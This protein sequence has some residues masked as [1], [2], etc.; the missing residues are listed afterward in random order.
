P[1]TRWFWRMRRRIVQWTMLVFSSTRSCWSAVSRR[2]RFIGGTSSLC[3]ARSMRIGGLTA[4]PDDLIAAVFA[5]H[6]NMYVT[7]WES[8]FTLQPGI[9]AIF[10]EAPTLLQ[11]VQCL[12]CLYSLAANSLVGKPP[13]RAV[14]T[15]WMCLDIGVTGGPT[16][17]HI[18]PG[19]FRFGPVTVHDAGRAKYGQ[20]AAVR[21][22]NTCAFQ[23]NHLLWDM[24][25][26]LINRKN[27]Y[28]FITVTF[29][30]CSWGKSGIFDRFCTNLQKINIFG[31]LRA[32]REV[33]P[34]IQR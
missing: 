20:R 31:R 23:A 6:G 28:A 21:A 32:D 15:V 30:I 2:S 5:E 29:T 4:E 22:M 3:G 1:Q 25:K 33:M 11:R 10:V 9:D 26:V 14:V 7:G 27:L 19:I 8:Q 16:P 18:E 24:R 12:M 13:H 34:H 17:T